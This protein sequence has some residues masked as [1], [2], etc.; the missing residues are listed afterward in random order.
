MDNHRQVS[1]CLCVCVCVRICLWER[2]CACT[3]VHRIIAAPLESDMGNITKTVVS[4][5]EALAQINVPSLSGNNDLVYIRIFLRVYQEGC[6]SVRGSVL[7]QPSLFSC[8]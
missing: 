7:L 4:S 6:M 8:C 1:V 3:A 2:E 5:K